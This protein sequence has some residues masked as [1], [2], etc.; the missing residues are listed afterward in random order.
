MSSH[1]PRWSLAVVL[2]A[3]LALALPAAANAAT[4]FGSRLI[5]NPANSGECQ[6]LCTIAAF[7]HPSDPNGDPYSGGSPSD[8]VITRFR[9]R[10]FGAGAPATVTFR[11]ARVTR[12]SPDSALATSAGAGP[13]VTLP[14]AAPGDDIPISEFAARV[15]VKTGDQLAVD[16]TNF[17][18]TYNS[19]GDQFSYVYAPPLVEGQGP[20]G[21]NAVT[22]ELLVAAVV[23]PDA[24]RDGFGDETQDGCPTDASAQQACPDRTAPSIGGLAMAPAAFRAAARGPTLSRAVGTRLRWRLSEAATVTF[25]VQRAAKGRRVGGRCVRQSRRN[26]AR[27][28]CTR[29]VT[30][31]GSFRRTGA[32]GA[33]RARFS[34][35]LRGR[36]LKPGRY[37]LLAEARDRAGNKTRRPATKRFR[38]VR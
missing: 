3:V 30:L 37:R 15:P 38:I 8:G 23:E 29:Y 4:T 12:Q 25:R 34:G 7:I 17:Q 16:G 9:I 5:Q 36:K 35:R 24:D 2:G 32:A 20:R 22:G 6:A 21:S 14:A 31:R 10:G 1:W 13:T 28:R 26:R 18:A 33:N 11:L 27:R 19:G